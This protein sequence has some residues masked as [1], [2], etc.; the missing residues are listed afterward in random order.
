ME[1]VPEMWWCTS[2]SPISGASSF[3]SLPSLPPGDFPIQGSNPRL[4]CLLHWQA[5]SLLL[6][7][8]PIHLRVGSKQLWLCREKR[9]QNQMNPLNAS[10]FWMELITGPWHNEKWRKHGFIILLNWIHRNWRLARLSDLV[11]GRQSTDEEK[12]TQR[13]SSKD[14]QVSPRFLGWM[15]N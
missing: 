15:L 9:T 1:R 10:A 7:L 13:K 11:F 14:L 12:A 5:G 8:L 2:Y 6:A 3:L 4:W